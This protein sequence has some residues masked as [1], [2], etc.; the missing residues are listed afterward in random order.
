MHKLVVSIQLEDGVYKTLSQFAENAHRDIGAV[1]SEMITD[2]LAGS[3]LRRE[4]A[5]VDTLS[6]AERRK[7]ARGAWGS[8]GLKPGTNSADLVRELRSEWAR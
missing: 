1:V 5:Q 7:L 3:W 8:W 4:Q 2:Q 6:L